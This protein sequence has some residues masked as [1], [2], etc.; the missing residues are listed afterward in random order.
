M[1]VE[2][3]P[4]LMRTILTCFG[5]N[6]LLRSNVIPVLVG[7]LIP[8]VFRSWE[9]RA[10]LMLRYPFSLFAGAFSQYFFFTTVNA[11]SREVSRGSVRSSFEWSKN[12]C[13]T[14]SLSKIKRIMSAFVTAC[15]LYLLQPMSE[16]KTS[17]RRYGYKMHF[18]F[19]PYSNQGQS[20]EAVFDDS[21]L[22]KC[23]PWL[24]AVRQRLPTYLHDPSQ[25]CVVRDEA[26]DI[27]LMSP[28]SAPQEFKKWCLV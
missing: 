13:K 27:S 26:V 1:A 2:I 3:H 23:F 4:A 20:R 19:H 16:N 10:W 28:C 6:I 21:A 25:R 24:S 8:V 18:C 9:K 12:S 7:P 22:Y 15:A 17:P 5:E 11:G 14:M